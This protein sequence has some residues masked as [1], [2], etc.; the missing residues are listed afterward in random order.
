MIDELKGNHSVR[1]LGPVA[2]MCMDPDAQSL[3]LQA[4]KGYQRYV[5]KVGQR[6]TAAGFVRWLFKTSR[7]VDDVQDRAV[8]AHEVHRAEIR[9]SV[10]NHSNPKFRRSINRRSVH[11][12]AYWFFRWSGLVDPK[13]R[14]VR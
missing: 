12:F 1:S 7:L 10:R 6:Q 5:R 2:L 4:E 8:A 13:G 3:M 11:E 14:A 9:E